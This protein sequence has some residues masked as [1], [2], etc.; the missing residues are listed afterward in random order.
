MLKRET[1]KP[2][3]PGFAPVLEAQ[4][5]WAALLSIL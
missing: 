1:P 5:L 2:N 3:G 4:N